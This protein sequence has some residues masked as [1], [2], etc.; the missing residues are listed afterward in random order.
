MRQC[1][2]RIVGIASIALMAASV[3]CRPAADSGSGRHPEVEQAARTSEPA[4][5]RIGAG[6]FTMGGDRGG[7]DEQPAHRVS[8]DA[9]YLDK[10]PVTQESYASLMGK[11]PSKN[12]ESEKN[13]V[14]RV[15]LDRRD[16]VLQ[17]PLKTRW[18]PSVLP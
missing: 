15:S 3:G 7:A 13:P 8:L 11:N 1:I 17:R 18:T 6:S 12:Q 5:V 16:R 10:Y 2:C 4:M 14:E 9:F